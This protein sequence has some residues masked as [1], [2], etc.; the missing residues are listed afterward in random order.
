MRGRGVRGGGG[1]P[2]RQAQPRAREGSAEAT[3]AYL[4][5]VRLLSRYNEGRPLS[6]TAPAG[7]GAILAWVPAESQWSRLADAALSASDVAGEISLGPGYPGKDLPP[8]EPFE[9][10]RCSDG[11]SCEP[12][13]PSASDFPVSPDNGRRPPPYPAAIASAGGELVVVFDAFDRDR[14]FVRTAWRFVEPAHGQ[15]AARAR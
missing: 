13:G 6:G 15:P 8:R 14:H 4:D 7:G 5:P 10:L 11:S 9:L 3:L 12:V 2:S 1:G